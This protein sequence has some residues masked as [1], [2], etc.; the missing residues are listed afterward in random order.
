[1]SELYYFP[2]RAGGEFS[3]Y[4]FEFTMRLV[5]FS[6]GKND[7]MWIVVVMNNLARY[8][9]SSGNY[10]EENQIIPANESIRKDTDTE[11]TAFL[12]TKD[13]ELGSINTPHGEVTFI[14]LVG[15]TTKEL[16]G[17]MSSENPGAVKDF[18]DEMKKENPFL[19]TDLTRK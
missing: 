7:P 16:E 2:E 13:P 14:Q 9:V 10:F 11:I 18:L 19:I 6:E 15:I 17:I 8:V 12:T 5:P 4:G 1:M 3:K